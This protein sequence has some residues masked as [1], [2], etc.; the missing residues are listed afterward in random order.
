VVIDLQDPQTP[1]AWEIV[2]GGNPV[3]KLYVKAQ[4]AG[5]E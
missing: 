3:N 1:A 2:K 5:N 4:A